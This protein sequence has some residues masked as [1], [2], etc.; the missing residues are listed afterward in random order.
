MDVHWT[1]YKPGDSVPLAPEYWLAIE[2]TI[3]DARIMRSVEI[4]TRE[5][6][7]HS[8]TFYI[9]RCESIGGCDDLVRF[10][11]PLARPEYPAA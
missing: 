3:F 2:N 5:Y 11:A 6:S 8:P 9:F 1:P 7:K 4:G 10:Y